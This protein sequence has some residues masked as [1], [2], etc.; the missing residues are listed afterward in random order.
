MRF[1]AG[2]FDNGPICIVEE[3]RSRHPGPHAVRKLGRGRF[4]FVVG[5]ERILVRVVEK[6]LCVK[7]KR[8]QR[9]VVLGS[10]LHG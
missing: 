7:C 4:S 3:G 1:C 9:C 6:V 10:A 8:R 2:A 5:W